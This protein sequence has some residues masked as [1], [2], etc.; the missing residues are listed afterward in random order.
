MRQIL[1]QVVKGDAGQTSVEYGLVLLLLVLFII[2]VTVSA[3]L[4][5]IDKLTELIPGA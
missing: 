1:G 4:G 5:I 2:A 3:Y